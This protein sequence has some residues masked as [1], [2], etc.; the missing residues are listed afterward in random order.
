MSI[1]IKGVIRTQNGT[2][3]DNAAV[4]II[5]SE[6]SLGDV[7]TA[8][9]RQADVVPWT[10]QITGFTGHL[11]NGW[12][13][14][15]MNHVAGLTWTEFKSEVTHHNPILLAD[16]LKFKADQ[17]YFFPEQAIK[18]TTITWTR[19]IT[20]FAGNRWNC[21]KT[22]VRGKVVGLTWHNFLAQVVAYN[23]QLIDDNYLFHANKTYQLPTNELIS[24]DISWTRLLTGFSGSRW[25]CWVKQVQDEVTGMTWAAF[26]DAALEHNPNLAQDGYVFQP[27]KT[28]W[29]PENRS[30]PL[31]H[32]FTSTS[33][34][35]RYTLDGLTVAGTYEFYVKAWGYHPYRE[36]LKLEGNTQTLHDVTL[37]AAGSGMKSDWPGY[38]RSSTKVRR[39]VNQALNMLGDDATVFESLSTDMQK[40]V[41]GSKF[42]NNPD[43][44]HHKDIVAADLVTI[45][46]RSAGLSTSWRASDPTGD[47]CATTHCTN[48]YR[49][50]PD[51]PKLRDV[52]QEPW[53]PGDMLVYWNGNQEK[54]RLGHVNMYVGPFSG[55]DMSGNTHPKQAGYEFVSAR[56][57][58]LDPGGDEIGTAVQP[59][60]R[61]DVLNKRLGYQHVQ[62]IRHIDIEE[63]HVQK[64]NRGFVQTSGTHFMLNGRR[65]SFVGANIRGLV[66][67][68]DDRLLRYSQPGDRD[69]QLN[70]AVHDMGARVIRVFLGNRH[71]NS[72]EIVERL[73]I[74]LTKAQAFN[75]YLI[76]AFTDFYGDTGFNPAGD[77]RFYLRDSFGHETLNKDFYT[78]GYKQHYLP[79]VD[80]I[81]RKFRHHKHILAWE[82]GNEMKAWQGTPPNHSHVLPD[83]FVDFAL[84]VSNRIRRLDPNHLITT[85]VI[86][87]RA[88]GTSRAQAE[89]LYR[90]PNL[91][92]LTTHNYNGDDMENDAALARRV[93]KPLII[94][95][96][97][98]EK[99]N[100]AG[101]TR[102]DMEKWFARGA[103]G[104]LQ[105]G[106]M[107]TGHDIGD[108][109]GRFGMD[110]ALH[111]DYD[112]LA[113]VFRN[114]A[115]KL[116]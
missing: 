81:V 7:R 110:R 20:G 4:W 21:W 93:G 24:P 98:F 8:A 101:Q 66:H 111:R 86:S 64:D 9:I 88:L 69:A 42:L 75:V 60:T 52:S 12:Q 10:H 22:Y 99:G 23:P 28:Y 73:K 39:L 96:A 62:R 27:D 102:A 50:Q 14:F 37:K 41:Y 36:R 13:K 57:D 1:S 32:V 94:E 54:S 70:S 31:Y 77:E 89:R 17:T 26:R 115:Q 103:R 18:R 34:S 58:Q 59:M 45:C 108:G 80:T 87:S 95:E 85:G 30:N 43:H 53:M 90:S 104:Y 74:V 44:V 29:L 47:G 11:W 68:G 107:A 61:E 113:T 63:K 65:F 105:W 40:L 67:Y 72:A 82:L 33:K 112:Q 16:R 46:L 55:I 92:F 15:V 35:G 78:G 38:S 114:F 97:G 84:T 51:H 91:D 71:R 83:L 56:S 79:C 2:A 48:H 106:F 49:P 109:D 100:R 6:E 76:V 3:I 19:R 5:G 25:H 116:R